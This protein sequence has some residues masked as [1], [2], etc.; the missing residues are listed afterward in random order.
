MNE[1]DIIVENMIKRLIE[2]EKNICGLRQQIAEIK[3][4]LQKRKS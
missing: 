1:A 2:L 3:I 4:L